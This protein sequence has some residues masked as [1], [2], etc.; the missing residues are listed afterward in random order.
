M[1]IVLTR[2]AIGLI[3]CIAVSGAAFA[4]TQ[5][6]FN[7]GAYIAKSDLEPLVGGPL[8]DPK[9]DSNDMSVIRFFALHGT[10]YLEAAIISLRTFDTIEYIGLVDMAKKVSEYKHEVPGLGTRAFWKENV[11]Y[12]VLNVQQGMVLLEITV[13]QSLAP[14]TKEQAAID[15]AK[16]ILSRMPH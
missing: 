1:K 13:S 11:T 5:S 9:I 14:L 15:I 4:Q 16:V 8:L 12:G 2:A 7:V 6:S 3:L 10:P